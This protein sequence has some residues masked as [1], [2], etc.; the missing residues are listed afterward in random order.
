ME[1]RKLALKHFL[2]FKTLEKSHWVCMYFGGHLDDVHPCCIS[3]EIVIKGVN[4]VICLDFMNEFAK[5]MF[6]I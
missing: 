1:Y 2:A 4:V 6:S 5:Q 3:S